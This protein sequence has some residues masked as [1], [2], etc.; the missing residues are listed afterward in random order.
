ME[1]VAGAARRGV[2]PREGDAGPRAEAFVASEGTGAW[3]PL[4]GTGLVGTGLVGRSGRML[5]PGRRGRAD[6]TGI[7]TRAT[8]PRR[9]GSGHRLSRRPSGRGPPGRPPQTPP[10]HEPSGCPG[11]A[12]A[13]RLLRLLGVAHKLNAHLPS[14]PLFSSR[15]Y[16]SHVYLRVPARAQLVSL[17]LKEKANTRRV[18]GSQTVVPRAGAKSSLGDKGLG[19]LLPDCG[20]NSRRPCMGLSLL[21]WAHC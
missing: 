18:F 12:R 8:G 17:S 9:Q 20:T 10:S 16:F 1:S 5:V 13:P 15:S 2:Q 4:K 14:L 19:F 3:E 11:L 6:A 21:Y 7:S